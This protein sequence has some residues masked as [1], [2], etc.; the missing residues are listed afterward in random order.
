M[1]NTARICVGAFDHSPRY[2]EVDRHHVIP[3]Y[4]A[5]LLGVPIH[6]ATVDLCAGCHD[7]VHHSLRHLI[8]TGAIGG[9]RLTAG[10]RALVDT[11]WVWWQE[12]LLAQQP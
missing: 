4:L 8:N 9:H 7:I 6:P 10:S 5:A 2:A 1:T 11:A 12:T 3:K